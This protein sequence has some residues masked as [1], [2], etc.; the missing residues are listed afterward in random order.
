MGF[1]DSIV[2]LVDTVRHAADTALEIAQRLAEE[3]R[4]KVREAIES[5]EQVAKGVA[6]TI[7]NTAEGMKHDLEKLTPSFDEKL[8]QI[9]DEV[10]EVASAAADEGVDITEAVN[11]AVAVALKKVED[12]LK[13]AIDAVNT[14][15]HEAQTKLFSFLEGIL[16]ESLHFLLAPV[17]A[18]AKWAVDGL[19]S[20]GAKLKNGISIILEKI[21]VTVQAF[22]RKVGEVLGP[23]WEFVKKLWKLLFGV[24]PEHCQLAAQ[25]FEERMKRTEQQLL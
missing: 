25:W 4:R 16:P 15:L 8:Q 5:A 23:I 12:A 13:A 19:E 14:F 18:A 7:T 17:K 11:A 10:T 21:K 6:D 22:N 24:E 20:F 1:F 9:I 3:A 2:Q